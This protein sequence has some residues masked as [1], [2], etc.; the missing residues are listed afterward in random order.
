MPSISF[1]HE[2]FVV[3]YQM[4]LFRRYL[5]HIETLL[6]GDFL[7][8]DES[9][10][11]RAQEFSDDKERQEFLDYMS[12][13]FADRSEFRYI[14]FNSFFVASFALFEHRLYQLCYRAQEFLKASDSVDDLPGSS[15][16]DKANKYLTGL[17]VPFPNE[18]DLWKDIKWIRNTRNRVTHNGGRIKPKDDLNRFARKH[19]IIS[20]NGGVPEIILTKDFCNLAIDT[21]R[22]FLL[23]AIERYDEWRKEQSEEQKS[24]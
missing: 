4:G 17:G 16:L 7:E 23:E 9:V 8:W 6:E 10:R 5:D 12:E 18:T 3:D 14:L 22:E 19:S 1:D 24:E 15:R 21:M 13:D 20:H 11:E 2:E